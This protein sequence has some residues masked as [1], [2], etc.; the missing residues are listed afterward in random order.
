[1]LIQQITESFVSL[2]CDYAAYASIQM[3]MPGVRW[4][5]E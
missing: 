5:I 3:Q 2:Y 1:M 4:L